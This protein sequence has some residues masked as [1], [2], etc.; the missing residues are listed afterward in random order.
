MSRFIHLLFRLAVIK[1]P[2]PCLVAVLEKMGGIIRPGPCVP[3]IQSVP[4]SN[5]ASFFLFR[6][7]ALLETFKLHVKNSSRMLLLLFP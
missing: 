1:T 4:E 3:F 2:D 7:F 5:D 6:F